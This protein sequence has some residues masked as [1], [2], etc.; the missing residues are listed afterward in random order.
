[1]FPDDFFVVPSLCRTGLDWETHQTIKNT[2]N[3]SGFSNGGPR[4]LRGNLRSVDYKGNRALKS[5]YLGVLITSPVRFFLCLV[6][7][8]HKK[9]PDSMR[10]RTF[11]F[12]WQVIT[13][14]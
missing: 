13:S 5:F 2:G 6:N 12:V 1:M 14:L 7:R 10:S 9:C 8:P 3:A 4:P 11:S